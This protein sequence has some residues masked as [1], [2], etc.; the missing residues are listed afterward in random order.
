[1]FECLNVHTA[2]HP[3]ENNTGHI[4]SPNINSNINQRAG[5]FISQLTGRTFKSAAKE[6]Y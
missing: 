3:V 4:T 2:F 5:R 6:H 1:M